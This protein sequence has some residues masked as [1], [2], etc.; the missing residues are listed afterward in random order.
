MLFKVKHND[1]AISYLHWITNSIACSTRLEVFQ[2][3]E[4]KN[5][6]KIEE[7]KKQK[8]TK[9]GQLLS[10]SIGLR[11]PNNF[12]EGPLPPNNPAGAAYIAPQTPPLPQLNPACFT[13]IRLPSTPKLFSCT[14]LWLWIIQE[15]FYCILKLP[16]K[17]LHF[18]F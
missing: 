1:N 16:I 17:Q 9:L 11:K 12:R 5:I 8:T 13:C 3:P 14:T 15:T 2:C 6:K 4:R 10:Q 7:K 18:H